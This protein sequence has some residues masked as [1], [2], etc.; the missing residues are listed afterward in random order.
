MLLSVFLTLTFTFISCTK[1]DPGKLSDQE[2]KEVIQAMFNAGNKGVQHGNNNFAQVPQSTSQMKV[3]NQPNVG[4]PIDHTDSYDYPDGKGGNIHMTIDL[5]GVMNYN[6]DPFKCLGGFILINVTEEIN[7]FRIQLSNGRE[8]YIDSSPSITFTGNFK[9][10]EGCSTF[11]SQDSFFHMEGM[12]LC[13]GIEY[14]L[15][16]NGSINTDGSCKE[17]TGFVNGIPVNFDY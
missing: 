14:D 12:Y 6:S 9:I 16:L 17:I 8:V 1:E 4:Y 3:V 2:Q 13:N 7:H 11:S 10:L 5:G 15:M